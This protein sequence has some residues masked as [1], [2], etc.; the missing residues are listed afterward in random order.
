MYRQDTTLVELLTPVIVAMGYELL[1]LERWEQGKTSMLRIYIDGKGGVGLDDCEQVSARVSSV[2]DLADP[3]PNGYCLEVSS[4]GWDRPL[5]TLA[6]FARFS[7][8]KVRLRTRDRIEGRRR[9]SGVIEAARNGIVDVR[10]DGK[11]YRIPEDAIER[12]CLV[13]EH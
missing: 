4:P 6:Q 11:N 8:R 5:F 9:I 1:G 2:L 10:A 12:A 3:I 13:S 7:G